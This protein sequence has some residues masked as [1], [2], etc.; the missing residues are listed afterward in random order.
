V[1]DL[2]GFKVGGFVGGLVVGKAVGTLVGAGFVGTLVGGGAVGLGTGDLVGN[3][4]SVRIK[5]RNKFQR[6]RERG[7]IAK[8]PK[9]KNKH[10]YTTPSPPM[11]NEH[12]NKGRIEWKG[13]SWIE[14][15]L[16]KD[17]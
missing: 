5:R 8:T 3:V 6:C 17:I 14:L 13:R 7:A 4:A 2:V 16:T 9:K 15:M 10:H 12:S 11:S 1:G